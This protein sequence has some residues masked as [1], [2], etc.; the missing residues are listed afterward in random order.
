MPRFVIALAA[1]FGFAAPLA[2]QP[3]LAGDWSGTVDVGA[4][5]LTLVLHLT[6][7]ADSGLY[8][9]TMDVPDQG[10]YGLPT[11][12]ATLD[13]DTLTI[14]VP[15]IGAAYTGV[16]AEDAGSVDGMWTQGGREFPLVLT[17][18]QP[19]APSERAAEAPKAGPKAAR[20]D[21]TGDWPA[22]LQI[23]GGG[24]VRLTLHLTRTDSGYTAAI[25]GPDGT[26]VSLDEALIA[27]RDVTISSSIPPVRIV[28]T[29]SDDEQ[30]IAGEWQQG[31]EKL[32][33]TFTRR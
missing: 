5:Q 32:P 29:V 24:E 14:L 10:A 23:P 8:T 33:V 20:G 26:R 6:T 7:P 9:V 31:G 16:V 28:G 13:G 18:A 11:S 2:A 3:D 4:V 22:A 25:T 1:L 17:R 21:L 15:N 19:E 30:T 27:G 12:D